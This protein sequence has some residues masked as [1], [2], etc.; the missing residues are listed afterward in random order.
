MARERSERETVER[1]G[2]ENARTS[3]LKEGSKTKAAMKECATE[4]DRKYEGWGVQTNG[5]CGLMV[6]Y[7][8]KHKAW[9]FGSLQRKGQV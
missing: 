8:N 9:C 5:G 2:R 1:V 4:V 3:V 6:K 7:T